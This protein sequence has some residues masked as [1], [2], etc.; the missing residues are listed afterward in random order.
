MGSTTTA[1]FAGIDLARAIAVLGMFCMHTF[2]HR[3]PDNDWLALFDG[4]ASVLFAVLAGISVVFLTRRRRGLAMDL[5]LAIR[6]VLLFALGIA[7]SQPSV[8]PIVILTTYGALYV[9]FA[10]WMYRLPTWGLAVLTGVTAVGSPI[11]T[12]VVRP[13]LDAPPMFGTALTPEMLA[14]HEWSEAT[15]TLFFTGLF[16]VVTWVPIF[17]AGMMIGLCLFRVREVHLWLMAVGVILAAVA[18][19]ISRWFLQVSDLTQR[20]IDANPNG[21]AGAVE[22]F[23]H[24]YGIPP[25]QTAGWLWVYVP[26]SGSIVEI[27]ASIG[28]SAA[29]IGAC[30]ALCSRVTWPL[31]PLRALG[32]MPLT[33]YTAH[34]IFLGYLAEQGHNI[35]EPN[36]SWIN[37]LVPIGFATVWFWFFRRGPMEALLTRTSRLPF[38]VMKRP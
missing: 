4:R 24:A 22:M 28:V 5:S 23:D 34:I 36:Y 25:G 27:V 3:Y 17:A 37:L 21:L 31:Y 20:V 9:L 15:Q 7:L 18:M 11:L 12:W 33:A 19:G 8:G 2:A 32:R 14:E 1:R 16:P 10:P 30:L 38:T 35:A 6:G 29:V 26:H 13:H